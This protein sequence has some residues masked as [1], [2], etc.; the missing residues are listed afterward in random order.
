MKKRT[1]FYCFFLA[2]NSAYGAGTK[3]HIPD[4]TLKQRTV[5]SSLSGGAKHV[6]TQ[7]AMTFAGAASVLDVLKS[8]GEMQIYDASG[9]GSQAAIG[10]R[11]FG[12]NA[13]TNSLILL[14]GIP[15]TNP[16]LA[17]PDL[18]TLPLEAIRAIEITAG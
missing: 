5:K 12:A 8:S 9:T 15:L 10:I 4:V 16:D 3:Q 14:N 13:G 11:G 6:I 18:N 1:V 7:Q 17:P 2:V